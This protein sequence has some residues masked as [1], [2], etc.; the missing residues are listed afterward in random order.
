[1][2]KDLKKNITRSEIEYFRKFN[3]QNQT[4]TELKNKLVLH[5]RTIESI[6][7]IY[8]CSLRKFLTFDYQHVYQLITEEQ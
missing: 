1:M 7:L 5:I 3:K 4:Q 2:R 8:K 6:K